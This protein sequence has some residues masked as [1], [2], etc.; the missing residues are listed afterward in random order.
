[1]KL[2]D[3]INL[4]EPVKIRYKELADGRKSLYMD[5]YCDG[6]RQSKSLKLYLIPERC[7][8]DR[9]QNQEMIRL[10]NAIKAKK[11]IALQYKQHGFSQ[12]NIRKLKVEEYIDQLVKENAIKTTKKKILLALKAHLTS[13]APIDMPLERIDD[14]FLTDFISYLR[15]V[16]Q[17]H[18]KCSKKLHPNTIAC[19]FKAF[20]HVLNRAVKDDLLK[21]NPCNKLTYEKIPHKLHSERVYLTFQELKLLAD[22]PLKNNLLKRAFLFSCYTGLRHSV[23]WH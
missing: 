17:S 21:V 4:R 10:A 22:T 7:K 2:K 15:Q 20:R 19:Y 18:S 16:E 23:F 11:I 5:V 8:T 6:I 9:L 3:L 1:M 12:Q 14:K 13:F